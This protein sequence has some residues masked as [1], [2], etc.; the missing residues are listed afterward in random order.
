MTLCEVKLVLRSV[1][2]V[3]V[4][5]SVCTVTVDEDDAGS[6]LIRLDFTGTDHQI[7][8]FL[9]L[10]PAFAVLS[11]V[12]VSDVTERIVNANRV[13][14]ELIVT[15]ILMIKERIV[16]CRNL[17]G[18]LTVRE[19]IDLDSRNLMQCTDGIGINNP[20]SGFILCMSVVGI[21]ENI[22]RIT[23]CVCDRN[24]KCSGR[25]S[26]KVYEIKARALE[27]ECC[28]CVLAGCERNLMHAA[29]RVRAAVVRISIVVAVNGTCIAELLN[30]LNSRDVVCA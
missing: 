23:V 20:L 29:V 4:N 14:V 5:I 21:D 6:I 10:R 9:K 26:R 7:T 16:G 25:R 18:V 22:S 28:G 12:G 8:E 24:N 17:N 27:A 30:R 3:I 13:D 1:Y 15:S 11:V 2:I 19:I